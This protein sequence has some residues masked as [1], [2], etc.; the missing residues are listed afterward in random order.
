[1]TVTSCIGISQ[2]SIIQIKAR[3]APTQRTESHLAKSVAQQMVPMDHC[4]GGPHGKIMVDINNYIPN[5]YYWIFFR[6]NGTKPIF[7]SIIY[8]FEKLINKCELSATK[9]KTMY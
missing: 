8:M 1:M 2:S 9:M 7:D 4:Y 5:N 3:V 6:I